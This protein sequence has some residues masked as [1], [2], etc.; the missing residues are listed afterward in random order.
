MQTAAQTELIR[1][2]QRARALHEQRAASPALAAALDRLAQWQSRR[3]NG[4]YA[5]LARDPRYAAAI[6]FFGTDLYGPGDFSRRDAD[7]ARVVP[8]MSKVLPEG[9]LATIAG[10][11]ELSVLSHELDR[12]LLERL[13]PAT[14]LS[15]VSYCEAYR[16]QDERR[17]RERQ[18]AL[19]VTVGHAL[20]RYVGKP[21]VRSA[22]AAM[23]QPARLA[24]FGALQD[25]LE[26]GFAA[27][28]RMDGAAEFLATVETRETALMNAIFAG[29]S[30]PFPEP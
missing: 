8:L 24:G 21:L 27:F 2:L 16:E 22:L 15:V 7:L 1:Q 19:I 28:R 30:D 9:V 5:D 26:R 17:S 6:A 4:T 11:M 29:D 12:A 23:R 14:P 18:I 20:D 13:G 3:L 25:L 10:A